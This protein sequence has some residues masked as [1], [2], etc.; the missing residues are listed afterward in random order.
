M[1]ET[2]KPRASHGWQIWFGELFD[3]RWRDLRNRVRRLKAELDGRGFATHPEV[4]LFAALVLSAAFGRS[5]DSSSPVKGEAGRGMGF[6]EAPLPEPH[7]LPDPPLEGEGE[8]TE[9]FARQWQL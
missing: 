2:P 6:A 7:P 3:A 8:M 9:S 4:K 5:Q 1:A